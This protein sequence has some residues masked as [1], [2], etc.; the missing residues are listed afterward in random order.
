MSSQPRVQERRYIATPSRKSLSAIARR[1]LGDRL[2]TSSMTCFGSSFSG[3]AVGCE[4]SIGGAIADHAAGRNLA[5]FPAVTH[6]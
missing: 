5:G 3:G 6:V 2:G 1:T 4:T